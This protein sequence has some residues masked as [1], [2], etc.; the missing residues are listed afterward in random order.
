MRNVTIATAKMEESIKFYTDV[1]GAKVFHEFSRTKPREPGTISLLGP[2]PEGR[3]PFRVVFL[4]QGDSTV[5]M[6][7]LMEYK[8]SNIKVK[9]FEKK[10]GK[11][12]P[13]F[14]VIRVE[15]VEKV[16]AKVRS[17]G[18]KIIRGPLKYERPGEGLFGSLVIIDPNG[19][20]L[21]LSQPPAWD[22]THPRP[23]SPVLRATIAVAP[24]KM[25]PSIKYYQHVFGMSSMMDREITFEPGQSPLG[26]PGKVVVRLVVMQQG[27]SQLGNVGLL[28]Y[29][30]PKMD[31]P[32]LVKEPGSPYPVV[33]VFR[34]EDLDGA[35][36]QVESQGG[37]LIARRS[38]ENPQPGQEELAT[39]IDPNGVLIELNKLH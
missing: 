11:P 35:L 4:Q 25:E 14:F 10:P 24:E 34:V 33:F 28:T 32:P 17:W 3:S 31:I 36:S 6:I 23:T 21:E 12:Y 16:A 1:F 37:T 8:D 39:V 22:P 29:L 7:G 5:G 20:V 2:G 26:D 27:D 38:L 30:E 19:V 15:D 13:I 18:S 9:P